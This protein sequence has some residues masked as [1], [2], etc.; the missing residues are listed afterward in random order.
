M[1][2]WIAYARFRRSG[3]SAAAFCRREKISK[4]TFAKW[5]RKRSSPSAAP[6]PPRFVELATPA[7]V[8]SSSSRSASLAA[9]ELE[10]SLPGGVVLRWKP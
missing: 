1:G 2:C 7:S 3:L 10:L 6:K 5:Q 9:G 8:L 4:N